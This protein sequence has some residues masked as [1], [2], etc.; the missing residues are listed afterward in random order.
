MNLKTP[1]SFSSDWARA[2]Y[3]KLSPGQKRKLQRTGRLY[4]RQEQRVSWTAK[5]PIYLVFCTA[6]SPAIWVSD[7]HPASHGRIQCHQCVTEFWNPK[8]K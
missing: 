6:H 3:Y 8:H 4:I 5:L 2:E 1:T 7:T